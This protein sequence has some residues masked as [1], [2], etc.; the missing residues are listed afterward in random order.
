[1]RK[2]ESEL[3]STQAFVVTA[4]SR[5][6]SFGLLVKEFESLRARLSPQACP[7]DDADVTRS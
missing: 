2:D 5:D 1:M 3:G 4:G 6:C 7:D